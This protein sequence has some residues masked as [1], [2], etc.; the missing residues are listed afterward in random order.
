MIQLQLGSH[1]A[2]LQTKL[3]LNLLY[4]KKLSTLC[5]N[6]DAWHCQ[7]FIRSHLLC[8]F[9]LQDLPMEVLERILLEAIV[10]E[11]RD[12][13]ILRS[14]WKKSA[15]NVIERLRHVCPRWN[16]VLTASLFR[17]RLHGI[18]DTYREFLKLT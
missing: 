14:A 15:D 17:N 3:F 11:L 1:L 2:F 6:V 18:I 9:Q 7:T 8:Y 16:N 4:F 5:G 13:K 12:R 10:A